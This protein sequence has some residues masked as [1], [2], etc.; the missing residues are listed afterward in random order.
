MM[1][2]IMHHNSSAAVCSSVSS[3]TRTQPEQ[4]SL[5]WA[6]RPS[7]MVE[8]NCFRLKQLLFSRWLASLPATPTLRLQ[9]TSSTITASFDYQQPGPYNINDCFE[10][11]ACSTR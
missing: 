6:A 4:E 9:S 3:R 10:L 8:D 1:Y 11:Q 7:S 5:P 2:D